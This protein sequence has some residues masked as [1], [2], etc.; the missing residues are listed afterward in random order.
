M[1]TAPTRSTLLLFTAL[2]AAC[3]STTITDSWY[4]ASCYAGGVGSPTQITR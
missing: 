2:L 4:D 3:A 1:R